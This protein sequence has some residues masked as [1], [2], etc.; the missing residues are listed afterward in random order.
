LSRLRPVASPV[1]FA[2]VNEGGGNRGDLMRRIRMALA[3]V[4]GQDRLNSW[5]ES[6]AIFGV[7]ARCFRG[8]TEKVLG[9][10]LKLENRILRV[11]GRATAGGPASGGG[12][13][14]PVLAKNLLHACPR[15]V[16]LLG[17]GDEN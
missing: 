8:A 16:Q 14:L 15:G 4:G 6:E 1:V 10:R 12:D 2:G 9:R 3:E 11:P 13:L 5:R 7:E 17:F